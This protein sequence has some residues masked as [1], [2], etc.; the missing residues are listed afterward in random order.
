MPTPSK[1]II[2]SV[3]APLDEA[4]KIFKNGGVVAYPTETFYGLGVDPFNEK[5]VERLFSLKGREKGKPVALLI[6]DRAMLGS[7]AAS[8]PPI[9]ER[10]IKKYWPGPLTI[11]FKACARIPSSVTGGTN[12]IG[13]RVSSSA[14]A[15]RLMNALSSPLT[16]TSANPS[17]KAPPA[18]ARQ[19]VDY[20]N[21]NI[22][23]LIDGGTLP[24]SLGSTVVD[25]TG[26][27]PRI[28]REGEVPAVEILRSVKD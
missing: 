17:G 16:A 13:V 5:A 6:K 22:D 27:E 12:T 20:F 19:V 1:P 10:L 9:A 18:A 24:G 26:N 11:I 4:V 7:V 21:G 25:V 14:V 28:L 23:L 2:L 15:G 8:I 3:E